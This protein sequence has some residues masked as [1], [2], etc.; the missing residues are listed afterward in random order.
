MGTALQSGEALRE[1]LFAIFPQYR[2]SYARYGPLHDFTPTFHSILIEFSFF[3]GSESASFSE[4]QLR[5]FG[6]LVNLA[7]AEDGPLENAFGT[8]L[9]EHLHQI[10]A[11]AFR[12]YLSK[13]ALEKTH[14]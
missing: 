13:I 7:V 12:P 11:D 4:A 9:L 10:R 5:K 3:F 2:S 14:A 1:E 6:E 8:C